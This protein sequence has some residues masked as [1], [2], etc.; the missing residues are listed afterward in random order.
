[1]DLGKPEDRDE[2]KNLIRATQALIKTTPKIDADDVNQQLSA[3]F[4]DAPQITVANDEQICWV[5]PENWPAINLFLQCQTQW[6]FISGMSV[7]R[8]GLNYQAVE[9]VMRLCYA[10]QN[11]TDLFNRLQVIEQEALKIFNAD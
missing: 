7:Q 11:Q 10:D 4:E 8:T 2:A 5:L 1:M 3:L 9:S 6:N